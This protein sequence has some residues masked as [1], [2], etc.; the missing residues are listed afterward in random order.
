MFVAL[1]IDGLHSAASVILK[2]HHSLAFSD[3]FV[4]KCNVNY[5]TVHDNLRFI[6]TRA[7]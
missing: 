7:I 5:I 4:M 3:K 6:I 2:P 1:E